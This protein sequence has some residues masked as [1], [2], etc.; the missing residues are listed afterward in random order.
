MLAP[1]ATGCLS[2]SVGG[3]KVPAVAD[4]MRHHGRVGYYDEPGHCHESMF[5]RYGCIPLLTND[6]ADPCST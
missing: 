1:G 4:E 5:S 3:V 2:A 6:V